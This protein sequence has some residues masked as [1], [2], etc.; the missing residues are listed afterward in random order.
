MPG[1]LSYREGS[2]GTKI[3]G[4]LM[5]NSIGKH[6]GN[7]KVKMEAIFRKGYYESIVTF[8]YG[9]VHIIKQLQTNGK[10]YRNSF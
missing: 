5:S 1:F 3:I 8:I 6:F 7:L 10:N 2:I 9:K 4:D